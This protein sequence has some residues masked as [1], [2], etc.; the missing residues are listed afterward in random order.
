VAIPG[1]DSVI[2]RCLTD[3]S[4]RRFADPRWPGCH[5]NA[6]ELLS[7]DATFSLPCSTPVDEMR[8]KNMASVVIRL[9]HE[10]GSVAEVVI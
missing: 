8:D 10:I 6:T 7:E 9:I 3:L 2:D 1:R 4:Q 5:T